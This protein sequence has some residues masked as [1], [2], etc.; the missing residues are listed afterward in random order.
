MIELALIAVGAYVFLTGPSS[1]SSAPAPRASTPTES[2]C[3]WRID[4]DGKGYAFCRVG[5]KWRMY[6]QGALDP[7]T[8]SDLAGAIQRAAGTANLGNTQRLTFSSPRGSA[9]VSRDGEVYVWRW[10]SE[11]GTTDDSPMPQPTMLDA[12][13]T[14]YTAHGRDFL[15]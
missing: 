7:R 11:N 12:L 5:T 9:T 14:L 13:G 3:G 1:S 8:F 15:A 4:V 6:E 10:T 2:N